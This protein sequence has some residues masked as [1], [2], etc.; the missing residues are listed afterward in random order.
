MNF[1][2]KIN[3]RED[4]RLSFLS[5]YGFTPNETC[6]FGCCK[7][8]HDSY[9]SSDGL[10]INSITVWS[11]GDNVHVKNHQYPN[12]GGTDDVTERSMEWNMTFEKKILSMI[13]DVLPDNLD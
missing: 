5:K 2:D 11:E 12:Y 13:S 4:G 9:T 1:L 3:N 7:G 6:G 10:Y 8:W